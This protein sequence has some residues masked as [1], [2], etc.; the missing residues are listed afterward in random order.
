MQTLRAKKILRLRNWKKLKYFVIRESLCSLRILHISITKKYCKPFVMNIYF[1]EKFIGTSIFRPFV[2]FCKNIFFSIKYVCKKS[3]VIVKIIYYL[4]GFV[5]KLNKWSNINILSVMKTK[6]IA[7]CVVML[8]AF[9]VSS[10]SHHTC[11][12]YRGS[13]SENTINQ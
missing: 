11:P 7:V 4:R 12:A 2:N 6:I 13:I 8:F 5:L 9:A 3:R 1:E 10:C